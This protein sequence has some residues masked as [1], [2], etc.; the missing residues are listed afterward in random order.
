ML[1]SLT[2][3]RRLLLENVFS[4]PAIRSLTPFASYQSDLK[5]L[6]SFGHGIAG[7]LA[8]TTVS[9]VA[10]PVEHIKA[11]LQIQ[12]AADKSK[13]MYSGPIDCLKKL[14]SHWQS[15]ECWKRASADCSIAA[16]SR[17]HRV[18]PRPLRDN[19]LPIVFL[20]LVGFLRCP[21][22]MDEK[23]HRDVGASNQFLGRGDISTDLLVDLVPVRCG[24]AATDD[25]PD[26]RSAR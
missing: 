22:A 12:Y 17:Y 11:R 8:G 23:Q 7:I 1:G 9:F 21:D 2:L 18:I 3:Y 13:R 5:T 26:G 10:A 24:Q 25:R 16:H 4:K 14:V 20:L 6:P 19:P 15:R